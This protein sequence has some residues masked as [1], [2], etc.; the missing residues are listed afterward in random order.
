MDGASGRNCGAY[1][2]RAGISTSQIN[3]GVPAAEAYD[4]TMYLM[5]G[6]LAVG[7]VANLLLRPVHPRH[8]LATAD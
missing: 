2:H 3:A 4:S 1:L 7:L 8:H 6:L 5:A